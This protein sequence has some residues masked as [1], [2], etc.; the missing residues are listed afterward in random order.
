M[1]NKDDLRRLQALGNEIKEEIS[2]QRSAHIKHQFFFVKRSEVMQ[3][4]NDMQNGYHEAADEHI[5]EVKKTSDISSE[6]Q[7]KEAMK[8]FKR[9]IIML[10]NEQER[11]FVGEKEKGDLIRLHQ[12]KKNELLDKYHKLKD[13]I[14]I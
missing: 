14:G 9:V 3:K 11:L 8:F 12:K 13:K 1:I 6:T 10:G 7:A 2:E 5:E 4:I